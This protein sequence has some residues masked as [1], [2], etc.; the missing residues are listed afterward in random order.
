MGDTI[1]ILNT[2]FNVQHWNQYSLNQFLTENINSGR[3]AELG[4][5]KQKEVL[6][7]AYN[8][9]VNDIT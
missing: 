3:F 4:A 6:T 9:I 8:L 1:R 2:G 7:I 5:D